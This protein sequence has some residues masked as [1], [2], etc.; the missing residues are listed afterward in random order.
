VRVT[1]G[2]IGL[3]IMGSRMAAN[4]QAHGNQLVVFNRSRDKADAL[5][6]NGAIWGKTPTRTASDVDVLFTMLSEPEAV[7]ATAL[8]PLG[9]L[10]AMAPGS[11][12]VNSSTVNPSFAR[13]MA[14]EARAKGVRY[15]DAPVTGSKEAAA[16]GELLFMVGGDA[17]DLD[18][19]RP[20]L[21]S[22]GTRIIHVGGHG[23]GSSLKMVNNLLGA[24][25]MAVFAE[26]AA[27][28]QA[29]GVPRQTIFDT[30]LGGPMVAP[31]VAAKRAKF[32]R[33]DYDTEFSLRWMQKDL[34]LASVSGYEA[35][36]PMAVVNVT[37]ELY[38]LAMREGY[39][40]LDISAMYAFLNGAGDRGQRPAPA[41]ADASTPA[42]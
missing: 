25:A 42:R 8:G 34:H 12:W 40:D 37:K 18:F 31:M 19:C 2:F 27:L 35:G 23:L 10:N 28:G 26:G 17:P 7:A 4:L 39:A 41:A 6:R 21:A 13:R 15:L 29:L 14:E 11:I 20:L 30:F 1:I 36:V 22:M 32:E 5:I 33:D 16:R 24:V 3:G 9:F 38:R